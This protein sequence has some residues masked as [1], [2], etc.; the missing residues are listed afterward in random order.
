[1]VSALSSDWRRD[2][3]EEGGQTGSVRVYLPAGC[4]TSVLQVLLAWL[5]ADTGASCEEEL[6]FTLQ[7]RQVDLPGAL[8]L[9]QV[10]SMLQLDELM[11]ELANLVLETIKSVEDLA[12]LEN[13]C[14]CL[15]LPPEIREADFQA[16]RARL[17]P[18]GLPDEAQVR[19]MIASALGTADG[20]VWRVVQKVIDRREAWPRLAAENAN[21]LL[22]F[23]TGKHG[24]IRAVPHTGFFWGSRDFL[25]LVCRFIR[26]RPS[27]FDAM[28]SAMFDSVYSMDPELP[29]EIIDAVFKE[30][31]VHEGLSFTQ[32]EHV[33][34]KL[35]QRE[36]QLEYLFHEW[37][38][39]FPTL[40][41]NARR[42][43]SKGLLPA[44]GKCPHQALDFVLKE[45][46]NPPYRPG[47][48]DHSL[49]MCPRRADLTRNAHNWIGFFLEKWAHPFR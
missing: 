42:A 2:E 28:V 5:A 6:G 38:P 47:Q 25:Y 27:F 34:T 7:W 8:R 23:A 18:A 41:C 37:S 39:V 20:K 35:M 30:L 40:P 13:A 9:V 45:L 32:C 48:A 17:E 43:L 3:K 49:R 21:I 29:P 4:S 10:A 22:S 31:L 46:E 19:G 36:D 1:V 15:E 33:I 26:K 14:S 24:S 11:P 16:R 44:V 12:Y